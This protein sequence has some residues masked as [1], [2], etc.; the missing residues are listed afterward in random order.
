M[1]KDKIQSALNNQIQIEAFSSQIY[2]A[3]ASWAEVTDGMVIS[4][5]KLAILNEH[6]LEYNKRYHKG[7]EVIQPLWDRSWILIVLCL[8]YMS[9]WFSRRM[10]G[11]I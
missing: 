7:N 5:Q 1:L 2:L 4:A 8:M 9:L 3:M 10:W 11:S 6:Y